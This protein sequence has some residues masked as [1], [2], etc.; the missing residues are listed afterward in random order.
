MLF[1]I[2]NNKEMTVPTII[3]DIAKTQIVIAKKKRKLITLIVTISP[4]FWTLPFL[5]YVEEPLLTS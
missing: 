3:L 2:I 1:P 4:E 5:R